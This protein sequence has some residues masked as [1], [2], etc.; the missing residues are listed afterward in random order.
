M[1]DD[2]AAIAELAQFS[3]QGGQHVLRHY[4]YFPDKAAAASVVAELQRRGFRTEMRLG[5]DGVNWLVLA[6]HKLVPTEATVFA[7][8]QTLEALVGPSGGEYDG[9]EVD[10]SPN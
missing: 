5:A 6:R 8:R 10:C 3:T 7:T 4:L 1:I 2:R 9:W